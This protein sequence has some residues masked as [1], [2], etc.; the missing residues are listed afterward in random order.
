[1][2][3]TKK[4][5]VIMVLFVVLGSVMNQ[6]QMVSADRAECVAKCLVGCTLPIYSRC[7]EYCN[8]YCDAGG[9]LQQQ[10]NHHEKIK[11]GNH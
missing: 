9:N 8:E 3:A 2:E 10:Y 7:V 6:Q 4:M 1:M 11:S 5:G